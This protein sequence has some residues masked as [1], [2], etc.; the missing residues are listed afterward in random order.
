MLIRKRIPNICQVEDEAGDGA[1]SLNLIQAGADFHFAVG[2]VEGHRPVL[3]INQPA[4]LG[5][6]REVFGHLPFERLQPI[7]LGPHF[8]DKV[9]AKMPEGFA[10]TGTQL[11]DPGFQRPRCIRRTAG[12]VGEDKASGG[13]AGYTPAVLPGPNSKLDAYVE[14]A[15]T[16]IGIGW[17][18]DD[19]FPFRGHLEK[20]I[21]MFGAKRRELLIAHRRSGQRRGQERFI[22][23]ERHTV[24]VAPSRSRGRR[25]AA[26]AWGQTDDITVVTVRKQP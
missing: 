15:G 16:G 13:I 2:T 10:L 7:A 4:Q 17:R 18:H 8:N 19:Q 25:R 12:A 11:L 6:L 21:G 5:P 26:Q 20:Q 9:R 23:E 24:S 22:N 14:I 3:R 1:F